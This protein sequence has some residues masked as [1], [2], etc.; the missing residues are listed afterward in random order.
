MVNK[1]TLECVNVVEERAKSDTHGMTSDTQKKVKNCEA[2]R[3]VK[4]DSNA[5][6]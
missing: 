1:D 6:K 2:S 3:C 4:E 5:V